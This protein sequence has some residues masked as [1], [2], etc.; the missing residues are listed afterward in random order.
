MDDIFIE[1]CEQND[2]WTLGYLKT[3]TKELKLHTNNNYILKV[4][5]EKDNSEVISY[6]IKECSFE[7]DNECEEFIKNYSF[8]SDSKCKRILDSFILQKKLDATLLP[9]GQNKLTKL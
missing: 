8:S 6:L 2:L 4:C 5:I 7:L 3:G 1:S 9:S